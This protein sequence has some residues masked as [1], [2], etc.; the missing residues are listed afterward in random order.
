MPV[1]TQRADDRSEWAA[2]DGNVS[3]PRREERKNSGPG[4]NPF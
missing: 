3:G 2:R 4:S 1:A